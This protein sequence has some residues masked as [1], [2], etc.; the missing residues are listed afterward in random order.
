M[1]HLP[2]HML[3]RMFT[4]ALLSIVG[5]HRVNGSEIEALSQPPILRLDASRWGHLAIRPRFVGNAQVHDFRSSIF[6]P[7]RGLD[8]DLFCTSQVCGLKLEDRHSGSVT[9]RPAHGLTASLCQSSVF[10]GFHGRSG[11][12][13]GMPSTSGH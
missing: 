12:R 3:P 2:L 11:R 1:S 6:S 13:D 9:L 4:E 5:M 10:G 8:M 7:L